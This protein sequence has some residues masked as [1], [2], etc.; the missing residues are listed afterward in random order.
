MTTNAGRVVLIVEDDP[1]ISSLV[2][3]RLKREGFEVRIARDGEQAIAQMENPPPD[4]VIMDVMI[5]FRDGYEVLAAFRKNPAW[6]LV[7]VI[8]LTSRSSEQDVARGLSAGASDYL[9]KPFRPGELLARVHRLLR[10]Q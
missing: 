3:F 4:L 9:T 6:S 1:N 7:P 5:P 8:M 2:E 10:P